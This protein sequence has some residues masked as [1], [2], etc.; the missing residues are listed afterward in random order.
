MINNNF[1]FIGRCAR[2]GRSGTAYN[3]VAADE[4]PYLLDLFLFLGRT[5]QLVPSAAT[6]KDK[7]PEEAIGKMPQELIEEQLSDLA[8]WH[9]NSTDIVIFQ[10][11]EL[12]FFFCLKLSFYAYIIMLFCIQ[13]QKNMEKVCSNGYQQY[14]RSR[15]AASVASVKRVKE[16]CINEAG[17][18]PEYCNV[19]EDTANILARMKNYRPLGV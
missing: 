12:F 7:V 8:I 13:L 14:L 5:F 16:L 9:E 3:I 11:S 15:P 17:Y 2:A 4:F 10:Y 6:A 1:V 19:P 18:L